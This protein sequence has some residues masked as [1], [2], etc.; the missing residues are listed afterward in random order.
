MFRFPTLLFA[1]FALLAMLPA[2]GLA[3]TAAAPKWDFA[4]ATGLFAHRPDPAGAPNYGDYWSSTWRFGGTVGRYWTPN[5]K[6]EVELATSGESR[7]WSQRFAVVPGATGPVPYG[8]DEYFRITQGS[9]HIVW[10]FFDNQWIHPY[11]LAGAAV[12]AARR[13]EV[14]QE[15]FHYLGDFRSP[16]TRVLVVP[17]QATTPTT[18]FDAG[19]VF[20]GGAKLYVSPSLF[21]NTTLLFTRSKPSTSV[22]WV[23]GLGI[24][25]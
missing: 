23:G 4:G 8:V 17:E 24:D 9:V 1:L 15:Q 25:F 2:R 18:T 6:T 3:Q 20:G 5:L 10:Q 19:L 7:R 16:T 12:N 21:A 14:V 22:S 13:R 11:L